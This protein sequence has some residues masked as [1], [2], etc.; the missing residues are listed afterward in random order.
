MTV[1]QLSLISTLLPAWDWASKK[2]LPFGA[3]ASIHM[4]SFLCRCSTAE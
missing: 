3:S 4:V 1:S 2:L